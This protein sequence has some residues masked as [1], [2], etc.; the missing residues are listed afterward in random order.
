MY[1]GAEL[2]DVQKSCTLLCSTRR[3][4]A[5]V[6]TTAA[7]AVTPA[8]VDIKGSCY[9]AKTGKVTFSLL[10]SLRTQLTGLGGGKETLLNGAEQDFL[11]LCAPRYCVQC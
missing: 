1:L 10:A 8:N 2:L 4:P 9:G 7:A 6:A 3:A 5:T 11:Q